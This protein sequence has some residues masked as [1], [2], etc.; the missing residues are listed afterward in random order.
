MKF[1]IYAIVTRL[2][3]NIV[4]VIQA[5]SHTLNLLIHRRYN[6]VS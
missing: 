2:L 6:D 3:S 1:I 5:I 4:F